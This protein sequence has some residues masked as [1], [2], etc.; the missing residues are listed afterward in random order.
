MKKNA[1]LSFLII[2]L[3]ACASL[4]KNVTPY[5]EE[6]LSHVRYII[7]KEEN[8]EFSSLSEG[9]P[10]RERFIRDFWI[11]RDPTPGTLRN[12]FREMYFQ[13]ID[14]ANRLFRGGRPGWLTDRGMILIL[15]GPP[16]DRE[17]FPMGK[18]SEE[19]PSEIWIYNRLPNKSELRL[20]FVD[21]SNT[22]DYKLITNISRE[23]I[24]SFIRMDMN[25]SDGLQSTTATIASREPPQDLKL[26]KIQETDKALK[27]SQEIREPQ[28]GEVKVSY[29][30]VRIPAQVAEIF[31]RNIAAMTPQTEIGITYLRTL[32]LPAQQNNVHA[33]FLFKIKNADLS[34]L[35][36]VGQDT[37]P[38]KA[39]PQLDMFLRI[40]NRENGEAKDIVKEIYVPY[41][42]EF[43][44]KELGQDQEHLY[45]LC[46][47][48]PPGEYVLALAFASADLSKMG[49]TYVDFSLPH[50]S[51]FYKKLDTTPIFFVESLEKM[52]APEMEIAIHR[53]YFRYSVLKIIP[54]EANTFGPEET[55]DIF[56][57]IYGARPDKDRKFR[58][59]VDY[60]IKKG[61][62]ELRKY[63]TQTYASPFVSHP[64]PLDLEGKTLEPGAYTL[65]I[66][67]RDNISHLSLKKE[68]PFDVK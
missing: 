49:T 61:N 6:F 9:S 44:R 62:E 25:L 43:D 24:N 16:D 8:Q 40:Y 18:T 42:L 67:I 39:E 38:G 23:S 11:Q 30:E 1:F 52:E 31:D 46:D 54:K 58:I 68:I 13:R 19:K 10:E 59:E 26:E 2:S 65:E 41:P 66:R 14:A 29:S 15:L 60:R 55:P 3:A 35:R 63:A 27:K 57:F 34:F 28:E 36:E 32:Y 12:E 22:N 21:Y 17:D 4:P 64:L 45:S 5:E 51:S 56:Y 20:E 48:L 33:I 47:P 50:A 7:T 53:D 37:S